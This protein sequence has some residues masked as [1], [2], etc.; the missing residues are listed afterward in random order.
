M[1]AEHETFLDEQPGRVD[2]VSG[3]VNFNSGSGRLY[4]LRKTRRS[5]GV[6]EWHLWVQGPRRSAAKERKKNMA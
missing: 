2:N 5:G 6:D 3:W 1:E 4:S